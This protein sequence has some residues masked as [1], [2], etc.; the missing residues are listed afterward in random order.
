MQKKNKEKRKQRFELWL[1]IFLYIISIALGMFSIFLTSKTASAE[2]VYSNVLE[3][4]SKDSTFDYEN[5]PVDNDDNSIKVIQIAE[6]ESKELLIYTYQPNFNKDFKASSI[7]IS[8]SD[9]DL[10]YVNYKLEFL[11]N[12]L[13][14]Y[15]YKVIDFEFSENQTRVYNISSIFRK[16]DKEV[17]DSPSSDNTISEV[18]FEVGKSWYATTD[19][20]G[21]V[22]YQTFDNEVIEITDKFVGFVRY[23]DGFVFHKSTCDSHFVA[24]STNKEIEKLLEADVYYTSQSFYQSY[25]D[26]SSIVAIPTT[27]YGSVKDNYSFLKYRDKAEVITSGFLKWKF[28]FDKISTV[29]NFISEIEGK[30]VFS[31]GVFNVATESKIKASA[32]EEL[33]KMD[34]VLRFTET[35]YYTDGSTTSKTIVGDVSILRLKFI[36]D[37]KVY[38]LGVIDNKQ[39]GSD[40][41]INNNHFSIEAKKPKD[42][43]WWLIALVC[44]VLLIA[45]FPSVAVSVFE[46]VLIVIKYILK[47]LWWLVSLPFKLI[48]RRKEW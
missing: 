13:T 48:K 42:W 11:N 5:Y 41:S 47:A 38:S 6:S 35:D 2:T 40:N 16:F 36:T 32:S 7:N 24:F 37:G 31:C 4:L 21:N 43:M 20:D 8:K 34:W 33:N 39:T 12:S 29:S 46:V 14:L 27:S 30:N 9:E 25:G 28:S 19:D 23:P 1:C 17:D 18:S 22:N 45:L 26:G 15:K 3:D 44:L 10:N